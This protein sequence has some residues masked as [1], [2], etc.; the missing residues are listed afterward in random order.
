VLHRR[1]RQHGLVP[2]RTLLRTLAAGSTGDEDDVAFLPAA[3]TVLDISAAL[4][5]DSV[6][7]AKDGQVLDTFLPYWL[8]CVLTCVCTLFY[9]EQDLAEAPGIQE[10]E[11]SVEVSFPATLFGAAT[12]SGA[13]TA[14]SSTGAGAA[15]AAK[16]AAAAGTVHS[17]L[18]VVRIQITLHPFISTVSLSAAKPPA[19]KSSHKRKPSPAVTEAYFEDPAVAAA[20]GAPPGTY[21]VP[22][23]RKGTFVPALVPK[24]YHFPTEREDKRLYF[25]TPEEILRYRAS[26][27][28]VLPED[29]TVEDYRRCFEDGRFRTSVCP[30]PLP[31]IENLASPTT[32]SAEDEAAVPKGD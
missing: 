20:A 19:Q 3:E 13:S 26:V 28:Y 27:E 14:G 15:Q 8:C 6:A 9:L 11:E 31:T 23:P 17:P 7:D 5:E 21:Y 2:S 1:R 18:P 29:V 12:Q 24:T 22:G 16:S 4:A 32:K 30:L 10:L 25:A